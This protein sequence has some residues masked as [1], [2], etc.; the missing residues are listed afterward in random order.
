MVTNDN[1]E[2]ASTAVSR[3]SRDTLQRADAIGEDEGGEDVERRLFGH[4][5]K[6]PTE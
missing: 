4:P 1:T 6:A 3:K 5:R 2:A